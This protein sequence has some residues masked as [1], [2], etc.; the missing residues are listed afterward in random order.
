MA[1]VVGTVDRRHSAAAE[2]AADPISVRH[3]VAYV[4]EFVGHPHCPV[5]RLSRILL[6]RPKE[7]R[8][9]INDSAN[10][11]DHVFGG[12]AQLV[13]ATKMKSEDAFSI[14][15]ACRMTAMPCLSSAMPRPYARSPSIEL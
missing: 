15:S 5:D 13:A 6:S 2:R 3:P 10:S 9:A 4:L 1:E 8:E 12:L 7:T 14:A 11:R